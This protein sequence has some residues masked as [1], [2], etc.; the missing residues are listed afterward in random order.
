VAIPP[1]PAGAGSEKRSAV[2][3]STVTDRSDA[4]DSGSADTDTTEIPIENWEEIVAGL[5]RFA[6]EDGA[7]SASDG[8]ASLE[9]GSA[10]FEI[11]RS[12]VVSA[13]MPL[14]DLDG[15]RARALQFDHEAGAITVL[16]GRENGDDGEDEGDAERFEYT[17]RRP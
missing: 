9:V 6:D 2:L 11:R 7:I 10:R 5:E 16:A 17:F 3:V 8:T 1:N 13:G 14:H 15:A 12:G 4:S